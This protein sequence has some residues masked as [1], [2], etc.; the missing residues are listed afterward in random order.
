MNPQLR[1]YQRGYVYKTGIK[2]GKR[3]K[4]WYGMWREDVKRP[5]GS[6]S[7]RQHNVRLGTVSELPIISG[8]SGACAPHLRFWSNHLGAEVL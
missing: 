5:D 6:I 3:I 2:T 4:V 7:R 1:R 8:V